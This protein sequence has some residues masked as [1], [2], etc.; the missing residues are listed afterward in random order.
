M[1]VLICGNVE[2]WKFSLSQLSITLWKQLVFA[3]SPSLSPIS[4]IE[5]ENCG[6]CGIMEKLAFLQNAFDTPTLLGKSYRF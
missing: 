6:N 1:L 5:I 4:F 2:L 3:L